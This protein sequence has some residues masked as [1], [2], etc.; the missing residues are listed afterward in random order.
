VNII[1]FFS[2][3]SDGKIR[4]KEAKRERKATWKNKTEKACLYVLSNKPH[5]RMGLVV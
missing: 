2:F 4:E 3:F 1:F 5:V